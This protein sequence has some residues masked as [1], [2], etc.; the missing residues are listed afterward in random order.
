MIPSGIKISELIEKLRAMKALYG[1]V[2]VFAG[3]GDYPGG[4]R[5]V[6]YVRPDEGDGYVPGNS[7]KIEDRL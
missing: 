3:G 4:V 2:E 6:Y 5:D 1:D 7:V